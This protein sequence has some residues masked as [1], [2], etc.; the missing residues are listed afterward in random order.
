MST[1]L[2]IQYS[3]TW[4]G[5]PPHVS[6]DDLV[7]WKK[8]HTQI[9]GEAVNLYFD[10]GLGGPAEIEKGISREME[11]A[12]I[13]LNQ[14]RADVVIEA[15]DRWVIVELRHYASAA[16]LGRLLMYKDLWK[17]DPP[18]ERPVEL[19]LVSDGYDKDVAST[20]MALNID[21]IIV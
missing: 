21:Y 17:Q 10:V 20:A 9:Y 1:D 5:Y 15:L 3:P 8:Y 16:A 12:W 14:K 13:R 19:R 18:D 7:I 2:G 6:P 4:G 11:K